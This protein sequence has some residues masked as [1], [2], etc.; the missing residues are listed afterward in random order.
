MKIIKILG[1]SFLSIVVLVLG[2]LF[3]VHGTFLDKD[4]LE[5]WDKSYRD[6]FD[7]PRVKLIAHGLLAA[8]A[9][10]RQSWKIRLSKT[11]PLEFTLFVDTQRLLQTSDPY[12]RQVTMSQGTF[13]ENVRIG[14]QQLGYGLEMELFPAGE[15]DAL[16]TPAIMDKHPVAKV[17][18][19]KTASS[20]HPLYHMISQASTKVKLP[21]VSL[22]KEVVQSLLQLNKDPNL[23]VLIVQN[24]DEV[25]KITQATI[26]AMAVD[27]RVSYE[28]EGGLFRFTEWQKNE[29][30]DG[31]SFN[32]FG[33]PKVQQFFM[34]SLGAI[35]P[36]GKETAIDIG[37]QTFSKSVSS[38]PA[39]LLIISKGNS[40]ELQL[41]SGMLFGRLLY[42]GRKH[43][44]VMQPA[45][46][47]LQEYAEMKTLYQEFHKTYSQAGETIQML[48]GM[49]KPDIIPSHSPRRDVMSLIEPQGSRPQH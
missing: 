48:A 8:S 17:H 28:D 19:H 38:I 1:V 34:E 35:I 25:A 47:I 4:Y 44:L 22:D 36:M 11:N 16:G 7:D 43:G 41:S 45:E 42:T 9:H 49:G 20:K 2:T 5:P 39:Y 15:Y 31:I 29:H 12:S 33:L 13:L 18:L 24:K 37:I 30:R 46:Q 27:L 14:A 3:I 32:P 23:K 6:R 10:N 21:N 40:R 26:D